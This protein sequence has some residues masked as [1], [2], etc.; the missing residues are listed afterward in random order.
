MV[1]FGRLPSFSVRRRQNRHVHVAQPWRT[2]SPPRHRE[3]RRGDGGRSGRGSETRF[4]ETE[5][6]FLRPLPSRPPELAVWA[7][8]KL[9]PDCHVQFEKTYYSAAFRLVRQH[10]WLRAT[11]TTVQ[12]FR[13]HELVATHLRQ[14]RPGSRST[15]DEHLPPARVPLLVIDDFGLKPLR[16]PQDED[17]HDLVAERYEQGATI[18]SSNLDFPEWGDAFPNRLLGAA[19]LDRLLSVILFRRGFLGLFLIERGSICHI[20]PSSSKS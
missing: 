15:I 14:F 5:R 6:E 4:V 16:A 3:S 9:H 18:I 17:F 19:T 12:L 1:A 13:D 8:V 2:F 7:R 20:D 10:L 11:E